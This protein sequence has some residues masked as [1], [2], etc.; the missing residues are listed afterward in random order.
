MW[1]FAGVPWK[2]S[3]KRQRDNRKRRFSVLSDAES[4][5]PQE[6][7]PT[8]LYHIIYSIVAIPLTQK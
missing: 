7:R 6:I 5:E 4:V 2:W 3:V 8:L 1:I